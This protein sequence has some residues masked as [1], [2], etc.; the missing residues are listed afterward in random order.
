MAIGVHTIRNWM[1]MISERAGLSRQYKNHNIRKTAATGMHKGNVAIPNIAHHLKHK[2][3]QTLKNYL[4]K[5]SL[6]DKKDEAAALHN[7][8]VSNPKDM[9]P[10]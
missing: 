5:P 4:E 10:R 2:D 3:I 9:V 6:E 8:T 1:P 7:Y